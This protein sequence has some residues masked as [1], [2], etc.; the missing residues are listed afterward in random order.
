[1]EREMLDKDEEIEDLKQ[2]VSAAR[3]KYAM[4]DG[5]RMAQE[6]DLLEERQKTRELTDK[7]ETEL[8]SLQ[9]TADLS[10]LSPDEQSEMLA[11]LRAQVTKAKA[12]FARADGQRM[13]LE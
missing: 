3:K 11:D 2:K 8:S 5:E 1:M 10:T 7:L 12:A 9:A 13:E 4:A 6:R